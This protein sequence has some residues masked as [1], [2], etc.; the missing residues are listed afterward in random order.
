V[1]LAL[2]PEIPTFHHFSNC[3]MT[4]CL[5]CHPKIE[6]GWA[7][8]VASLIA[9]Q[10]KWLNSVGVRFSLWGQCSRKCLFAENEFLQCQFCVGRNFLSIEPATPTFLEYFLEA[11]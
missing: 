10:S 7:V 3:A 11:G 1:A 5:L 4:T 6:Q 2:F 8:V 9:S